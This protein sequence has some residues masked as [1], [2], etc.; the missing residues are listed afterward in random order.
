MWYLTRGSGI[1][2]LVLLTGTVLLGIVGTMRFSSPKWPR[3][4]QQGLHRNLSLLCVA[5]IPIH[6]IASVADGFVPISIVDA[7]I[8]FH[9]KYRPVWVGLGAV[10]L[11]LMLAIIATSLLRHKIGYSSWKWIHYLAYLSWPIAVLH[12]L[13]TGSDVKIPAFLVINVLAVASV[14]IALGWKL[15]VVFP[16]SVSS[17]T[18]VTLAG[19]IFVFGLV[20]FTIFGPLT[21]NWAKRSGSVINAQVATNSSKSTSTTTPPANKVP[22]LPFTSNFSGTISQ[23]SSQYSSNVT[24]SIVGKV[25]IGGGITLRV[26]ISGVAAEGGVSMETS[27]VSFG[28]A[29]GSISNL[30]GTDLVAS[31]KSPTGTSFILSAAFNLSQSS[32]SVTGTVSGKA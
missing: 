29:T 7:V 5:I 10:S 25:S 11:D 6:V 28:S 32:T 31:M 8:P 30:S 2:A 27:T 23:S 26:S 3:F 15:Y 4:L 24:I 14:L 13:G 20:I 16:A 21:P 17:K 18:L 22:T 9:S 12:G 1:V 19:L